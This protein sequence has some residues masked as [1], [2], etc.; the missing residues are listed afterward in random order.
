MLREERLGLQFPM[1]SLIFSMYSNPPNR[2][3][4]LG[5]TQ[6]LRKMSTR[7]LPLGG[8]VKA[9][10]EHKADNFTAICELIV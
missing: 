9:R 3:M 8:K 6:P 4:A 2:T 5:L 1:K 7:N 10:P